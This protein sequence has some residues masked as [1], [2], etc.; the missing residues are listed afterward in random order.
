MDA[1]LDTIAIAARPGASDEER[2]RGASACRT[3]AESLDACA[4]ALLAESLDGA[5]PIGESAN[6][7]GVNPF[8]GLSADQILDVAIAR[9]R[10]AVGD[11]A[12]DARSVGQPLRLPLVPIPRR[13]NINI[14][15]PAPTSEA[16]AS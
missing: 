1:I 3:L 8:A 9:L 2:R 16:G 11:V 6:T 10:S 14:A 7:G 12:P 5:A 15:T 13:S 4:L